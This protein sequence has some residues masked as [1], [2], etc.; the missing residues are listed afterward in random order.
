MIIIKC[1]CTQ[2]DELKG[3]IHNK[4]LELHVCIRSTAAMCALCIVSQYLGISNM[5]ETRYFWLPCKATTQNKNLEMKLIL[6]KVHE[7]DIILL[8]ILNHR[9]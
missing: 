5:K 8:G 6:C 4:K 1:Y 7:R 2:T 3:K 9:I